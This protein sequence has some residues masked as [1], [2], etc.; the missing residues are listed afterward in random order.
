MRFFEAATPAWTA[1]W[2]AATAQQPDISSTLWYVGQS[3]E[4][5][6]RYIQHVKAMPR[7]TQPMYTTIRVAVKAT[8]LKPRYDSI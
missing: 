2:S 5:G 8:G 6:V 4:A 3:I 1:G 7:D